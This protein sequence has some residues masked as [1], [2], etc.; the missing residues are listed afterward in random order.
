[1]KQCLHITFLLRA[2]KK[3]LQTVVQ[4]AARDLEIEGTAQS[5]G[6]ESLTIMIVACGAKERLS[7]FID[8]LHK[9]A[10]QKNIEDLQIEPFIKVKDY[11]GVFRVIE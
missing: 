9:E 10:V 2:Q 8:I 7:D 6:P 1:M 4:K 11:R 5:S 3:I